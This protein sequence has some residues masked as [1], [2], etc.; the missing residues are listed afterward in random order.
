MIRKPFKPPTF[1][2]KPQPQQYVDTGDSD[3]DGS[4]SKRRRI[5]H[6]KDD[7]S[8]TVAIPATLPL[9]AKPITVPRKQLVVA[10]NAPSC[11]PKERS[12]IGGAHY[13]ALW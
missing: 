6:A 11:E 1:L 10:R 8:D 2:K 9:V 13:T 12:E 3:T 4:S 7:E 5:S